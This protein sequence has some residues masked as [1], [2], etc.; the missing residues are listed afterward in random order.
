MKTKTVLVILI[1]SLVSGNLFAQKNLD[2]V[3]EDFDKDKSIKKSTETVPAHFNGGTYTLENKKQIDK[4][5]QAFEKDQKDANRVLKLTN[6]DNDI[7]SMDLNFKNEGG[8]VS[9]KID[10]QENNKAS[11][12]YRIMDVGAILQ[13]IDNFGIRL[14][15]DTANTSTR[16]IRLGSI[17]SR[18][19]GSLSQ[20]MDSLIV[21]L[22]IDTANI[23]AH[24]IRLDSMERRFKNNTLSASFSFTPDTQNSKSKYVIQE[25]THITINGEKVTAEEARKLGFDVETIPTHGIKL[26]KDKPKFFIP[27]D[28]YMIID[29][30]KVTAEEARKMGHDVETF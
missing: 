16:V 18:D 13:N 27:K 10:I 9:Y 6:M 15:R 8:D 19:K 2:A 7:S 26:I 30:K 4:A 28:S 17:A 29:G 1:C 5:L 23:S 20:F 24:T 21:H 11:F 22:N 12:Q 14:N 3:R 25:N